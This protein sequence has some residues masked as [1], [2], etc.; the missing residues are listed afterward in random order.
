MAFGASS[1]ADFCCQTM[2]KTG[3]QELS[4]REKRSELSYPLASPPPSVLVGKTFA[5]AWQAICPI[6]LN[7]PRLLTSV[8]GKTK[9]LV[10]KRE[11]HSRDWPPVLAGVLPAEGKQEL[12]MLMLEVKEDSQNYSLKKPE[13][14]EY[15]TFYSDTP[16]LSAEHSDLDQLSMINKTIMHLSSPGMTSTPLKDRDSV[17]QYVSALTK[18]K[19]PRGQ[20]T[21]FGIRRRGQQLFMG[22]SPV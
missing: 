20:G 13:I 16:Q 6:G 12:C 22:D 3:S 11:R 8:L 15:E 10:R 2:D 21:R 4:T 9:W 14:S 17:S 5:A 19:N 1:D 18:N 7:N